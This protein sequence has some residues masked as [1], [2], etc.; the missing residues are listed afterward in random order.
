MSATIIRSPG[1]PTKARYWLVTVA[2]VAGLLNPILGLV[3]SVAAALWMRDSRRLRW[4]LWALA[5]VWF[6]VTTLV[7]AFSGGGLS[8]GG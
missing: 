3:T 7:L 8:L 2:V 4:V 6:A 5:G 1:Q